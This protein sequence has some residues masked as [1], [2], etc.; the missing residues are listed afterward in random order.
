MSS[1]V[2]TSS[3]RDA[4]IT[5]TLARGSE[6]GFPALLAAYLGPV[7]ESELPTIDATAL[8]ATVAA[9]LE[10]GACRRVGQHLVRVLPPGVGSHTGSIVALLVT[11]DRPFLVDTISM[12]LTR[13][14]WTLRRLYH[15]QLRVR[16]DV[17]GRVLDLTAGA[18]GT[19]ESWIAVEIYPPLGQAAETLTEPLLAGLNQALQ[20]TT[21]AVDDWRAMLAKAE[22]AIEDLESEH[23]HTPAVADAVDLLNWLVD[24]HFVFL[25]YAD[26][27]L[28]DG[29]LEPVA[30]SGLGIL[31][32]VTE[33]DP[34]TVPAAGERDPLVLVR[35]PRRSPVH[36]PV[37]LEHL[38]VRRYAPGGDLVR[39]HRFLG[40]LATNAYTESVAIIPVLAA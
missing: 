13:Q 31:R 39:E 18:D 29:R 22:D 7:P 3:T 17:S 25:G 15:P 21:V 30:G 37:Y 38:A 2:R 6:P 16:R 5:A 12:E 34:V 10:L 14:E 20:D 19:A 4:L 33:S 1:L 27:T 32:G 8:A 26:Y 36:R 11:E 24:D 35:N 28:R 23:P 9:H 40:L